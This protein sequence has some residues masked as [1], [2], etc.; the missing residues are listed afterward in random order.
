[1]PDRPAAAES[2][3]EFDPA[4]V[5][6]LRIVDDPAENRDERLRRL[7]ARHA[8][9][10]AVASIV[11][12][13]LFA[14]EHPSPASAVE[15]A[16]LRTWWA[17][18]DYLA[19]SSAADDWEA[20]LDYLSA[21]ALRWGDEPSVKA[22]SELRSTIRAVVT[23]GAHQALS[24]RS[25]SRQVSIPL[26]LRGSVTRADASV[27]AYLI[28]RD[29]DDLREAVESWHAIL[30]SDRRWRAEPFLQL[31][32]FNDAGTVMRDLLLLGFDPLLAERVA[33]CWKAA[34]QAF[35]DPDVVPSAWVASLAPRLDLALQNLADVLLQRH[36][37]MQQ[38]KDLQLAIRYLEATV[39]IT[40][41]ESPI[42]PSY[43]GQLGNALVRHP[44]RSTAQR[45]IDVLSYA[46]A[47]EADDGRRGALVA[48]LASARKE[49]LERGEG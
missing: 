2:L 19:A 13:A 20:G 25:K 34:V 9:G 36:E 16:D 44:E 32:F 47:L 31:S 17:L 8:G 29:E 45:G 11:V 1:M 33:E 35:E 42:L 28:S 21:V 23:I 4:S 39:T 26:E 22:F 43:L 41:P 14:S 10:D 37:R 27:V 46:V 40:A 15:L 7:L 3:A 49:F 5:K 6:L 48:R 12:A 30:M 18:S 38:P 24:E